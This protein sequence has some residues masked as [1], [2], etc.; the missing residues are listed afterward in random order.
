MHSRSFKLGLEVD[1][2]ARPPLPH[3]HVCILARKHHPH[4]YTAYLPFG[5]EESRATLGRDAWESM[6]QAEET[7]IPSFDVGT[8]GVGIIGGASRSIANNNFLNS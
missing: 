7:L 5:I 8:R 6:I 3:H 2:Q 4:R 1:A